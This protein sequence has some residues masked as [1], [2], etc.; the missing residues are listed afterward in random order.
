[1]N[2]TAFLA[3]ER[4]E[5]EA[6]WPRFDLGKDHPGLIARRAA[7]PL[8]RGKHG[9]GNRLIFGHGASLHWAG[10]LPNSLSPTNAEDGTVISPTCTLGVERYDQ[11]CSCG[12]K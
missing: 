11:Y 1:M 9:Y 5:I 3:L 12:S 4:T 2:V 8:N 7:G 6:V 10:A